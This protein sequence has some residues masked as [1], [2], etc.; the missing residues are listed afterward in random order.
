MN[1]P[2]F[3]AKALHFN[4]NGPRSFREDL[5]AH[6]MHGFVYSTPS[7]FVMARMVSRDWPACDIINP[8]K[9]D[10]TCPPDCLHIYLAAGDIQEFWTFPHPHAVW[11]SF[12]RRNILRFHPY[13]RIQRIQRPVF[14]S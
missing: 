2:I 11:V 14:H 9:N 8:W 5:E 13:E 7:A 12:E 3:Q 10:L 1:T 4:E 6:L